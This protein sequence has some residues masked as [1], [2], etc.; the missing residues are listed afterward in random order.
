M[1]IPGISR[2]T[3]NVS[4]SG[5]FGFQN[6]STWKQMKTIKTMFV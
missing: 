6:S 5:D 2:V 4:K 1:T 3:F